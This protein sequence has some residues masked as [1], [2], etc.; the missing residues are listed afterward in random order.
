MNPIPEEIVENTWR[1]MAEL[2]PVDI[3]EYISEISTD[4]P[5]IFAFLMATGHHVFNEDE[6]ETVMYLGMVVWRIMCQ[7]TPR[8]REISRE[9]V[10]QAEA[11]NMRVLQGL[12][13]ESPGDFIAIT[14]DMLLTYGQIEVLG[15]VI[16]SLIMNEDTAAARVR[17]ENKGWIIMSL[18]TVIDS[19]DVSSG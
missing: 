2:E 10:E 19:F 9:V 3:I 6:R 1:E 7:G 17:E 12:A 15:Y 18:K 14:E 5:A 16:E 4:Q 11:N 8:P 13:G